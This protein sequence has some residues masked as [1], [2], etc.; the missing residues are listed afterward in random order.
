[1][2]EKYKSIDDA[3]RRV[4][5][6][7][8]PAKN[9]KVALVTIVL[10]GISIPFAASAPAQDNFY[11]GRHITLIVS[12]AAG[13]LYDTYARLTANFLPQYIP[14]NP[15]VIVQNMPGAGGLQ[16]TNYMYNIAPRDG[17]VIAGTHNSVPM[18][19]LLS[20]N[21]AQFDVNRL[22]WIGSITSEPFLGYVMETSPVDSFEDAKTTELIMGGTSF[23][24]AGV[25]FLIISN[26]WFGTKF[27][28]VG[29]YGSTGD[30]KLAMENG[31]L[32]GTFANSYGS[33]KSQSPQWLTD[34]TINVIIQHGLTPHPDFPDVPLFIDQAETEEQRQALQFLLAGQ[35]FSKP[36][37]A[38]PDIPEDRLEILRTAF[39][40][41][42]NDPEFIEAAEAMNADVEAPMTGEELAEAVQAISETPRS[43]VDLIQEV[44]S[45]YR[46]G[47]R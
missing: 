11:E 20:P 40:A 33:L 3:A 15:D 22:S 32:D 1:M 28:L 14:G 47:V 7:A 30:I 26:A 17:T 46:D 39:E 10:W 16:A 34:G 18:A 41:M 36:Y 8:H 25:D 37:F 31:E 4:K 13:T 9:L 27:N 44:L 24:A 5:T 35:E 45:A 19:P 43:V 38:P 12:T 29:G 2:N 21:A 23:G 42:V 6:S